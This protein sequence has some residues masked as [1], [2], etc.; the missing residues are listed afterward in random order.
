MRL[1]GHM[2]WT[3][4]HMPG[5]PSSWGPHSR[6]SGTCSS[7]SAH[8]EEEAVSAAITHS[9]CSPHLI[10]SQVNPSIGDDPHQAGCEAPVQGPGPLPL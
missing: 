7:V 9:Q 8:G 1:A 2:Y 10:H 6:D 3:L 4:Y 5:A